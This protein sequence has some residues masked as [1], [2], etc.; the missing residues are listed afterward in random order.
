MAVCPVCK[1]KYQN[2]KTHLV[3]QS[4]NDSKHKKYYDSLQKENH[5]KASVRTYKKGDV[6][7]MTK[8]RFEILEDL[9]KKVVVRF[10]GTNLIK[11]TIKK[12][13]INCI[14]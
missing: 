7:E 6:I 4:K 11:L 8:N 14:I 3:R 5:N 1:K 13:R 9:G 10:P 12:E 2:L